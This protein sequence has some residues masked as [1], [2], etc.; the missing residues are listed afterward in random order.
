MKYEI[1]HRRRYTFETLDA[2]RAFA[3]EVFRR[4]GN[5]VGIHE[6]KP[7]RGPRYAILRAG[8]GGNLY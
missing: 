7:Q 1:I 4:T 5:V 3:S 6:I 2:A 8:H